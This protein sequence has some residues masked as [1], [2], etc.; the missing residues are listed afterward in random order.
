MGNS[1]SAAESGITHISQ[2]L[3]R[4]VSFLPGLPY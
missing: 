2:E 4:D 3:V 1:M